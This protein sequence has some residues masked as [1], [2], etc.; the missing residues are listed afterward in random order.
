MSVAM[1]YHFLLVPTGRETRDEARVDRVQGE[2][3][4]S[5]AQYRLIESD[6]PRIERYVTCI[7]LYMYFHC[8]SLCTV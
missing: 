4:I 1:G 8:T 5:C 2:M 7:Q 3:L 6:Q